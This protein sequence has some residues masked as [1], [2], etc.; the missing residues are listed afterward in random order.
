M[1]AH[2]ADTYAIRDPSKHLPGRKVVISF[3][4]EEAD[5]ARTMCRVGH[6][7][8]QRAVGAAQIMLRIMRGLALLSVN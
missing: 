2:H 6:V 3:M 5:R 1:L 4:H 7:G 8:T